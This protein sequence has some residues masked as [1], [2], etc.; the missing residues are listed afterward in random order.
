MQT[1]KIGTKTFTISDAQTHAKTLTLEN[2]FVTISFKMGHTLKELYLAPKIYAK[3]EKFHTFY[4]DHDIGA[5]IDI[6]EIPHGTTKDTVENTM[7]LFLARARE[8]K[9]AFKKDKKVLLNCQRGRSRSGS[10][11]ALF[12]MEY[13]GLSAADAISLV[14][15]A[16]LARGFST[17]GI[18][19]KDRVSYGD[20]L[21]AYKPAQENVQDNTKEPITIFRKR[22]FKATGLR[23]VF[24]SE[25][26]RPQL[27]PIGGLE[28]KTRPPSTSV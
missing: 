7:P 5:N 18:D 27:L 16:L 21:R 2:S 14:S 22:Q 20:W 4:T 1:L 6:S 23:D 12:F 3:T 13:L 26:K 15:T 19:L 28:L 8:I 11:A 10:V 9:L 17:G 25:A 24:F